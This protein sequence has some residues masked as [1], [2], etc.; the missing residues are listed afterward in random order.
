MSVALGPQVVRRLA[1]IRFLYTE[2]LE[3]A[4]RAQ[5]LAST[6]LPMFHDAVEMFLLLAAEHLGVTLPKHVDFEGYVPDVE[7]DADDVGG[8]PPVPRVL[9]RAASAGPVGRTTGLRTVPDGCRSP[10]SHRIS[11]D[12]DSQ[13]PSVPREDMKRTA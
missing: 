13:F 4:R 2:G 5:P 7:R 1:F 3:D 8:P 9:Q 10:V 12:T 11:G 6:A